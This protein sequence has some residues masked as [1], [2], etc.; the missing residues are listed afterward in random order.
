MDNGHLPIY[1][2]LSSSRPPPPTRNFD[3]AT[4]ETS[5]KN[6]LLIILIQKKPGGLEVKIVDFF[7]NEI[8]VLIL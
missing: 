3:M 8:I 1:Q 5:K 2:C 4:V 6:Y 7:R